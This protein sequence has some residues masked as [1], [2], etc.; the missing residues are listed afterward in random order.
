VKP[1][2]AIFTLMLISL[3]APPLWSNTHEQEP[4]PPLPEQAAEAEKLSPTP[5]DRGY[6][7]YDNHCGGCHES[8]LHI[9]KNTK[10]RTFRDVRWQVIRWTLNLDLP[11]GVDEVDAVS[12]YLNQQFYHYRQEAANT[13]PLP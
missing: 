12:T 10:A 6:L 8:K 4:A 13:P 5:T 2:K 3:W 7:L 1:L 9:R 11:W